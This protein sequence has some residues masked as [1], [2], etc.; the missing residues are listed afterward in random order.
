MRCCRIWYPMIKKRYV[1]DKNYPHFI[2]H[3]H[4]TSNVSH[5][6]IYLAHETFSVWGGL[7]RHR[8]VCGG[9]GPGGCAAAAD[10][11]LQDGAQPHRDQ[12][13][14]RRGGGEEA[15]QRGDQ[16]ARQHRLQAGAV[17]PRRGALHQRP[18]AVR[19]GDP[20]TFTTLSTNYIHFIFFRITFCSQIVPKLDWS[21][22]SIRML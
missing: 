12:H 18:P 2:I 6:L 3:C 15:R 22:G 16:A 19:Q 17:Q 11:W 1:G 9:A 20:D 21:K 8:A 7:S 10:G 13:P 14:G 5:S 4:Q